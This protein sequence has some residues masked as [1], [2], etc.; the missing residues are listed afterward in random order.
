MGV[1][2]GLVPAAPNPIH[3]VIFH[4]KSEVDFS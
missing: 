4:L 1:G 2:D 3:S